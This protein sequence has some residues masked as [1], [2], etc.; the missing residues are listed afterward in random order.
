MLAE[1]DLAARKVLAILD[2]SE[3]RDFTDL[4]ALGREQCIRWAKEL[5]AG[6]TNEAIASAFAHLNR[7]DDS[8]LPTA[9]PAS[10]RSI[11]DQWRAELEG[12]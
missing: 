3:G 11:Y 8:E 6:V 1:P 7:L 5:D 2:R 9:T 12:G 10:T 4:E